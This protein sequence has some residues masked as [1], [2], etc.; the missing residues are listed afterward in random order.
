MGTEIISLDPASSFSHDDQRL[1]Y[2]VV[3]LI[4]GLRSELGISRLSRDR[5]F[6]FQ[7]T[8]AVQ[9]T[10]IRQLVGLW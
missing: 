3:N 9:G 6:R 10:W 2:D 5:P 4:S 7:V 1:L 8:F